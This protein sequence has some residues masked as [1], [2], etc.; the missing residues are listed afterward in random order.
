MQEVDGSVRSD[1][2]LG[3]V[4]SVDL[5]PELGGDGGETKVGDDTTPPVRS[6]PSGAGVE[7]EG[8]S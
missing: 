1:G 4:S 7:P 5:E 3:D 2:R 8:C 6:S